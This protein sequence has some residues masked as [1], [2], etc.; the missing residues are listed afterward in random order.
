MRAAFNQIKIS[1]RTLEDVEKDG[2]EEDECGCNKFCTDYLARSGTKRWKK[3]VNGIIEHPITVEN[4]HWGR[5]LESYLLTKTS[6]TICYVWVCQ[7]AKGLLISSSSSENMK[8]LITGHL[9]F[10]FFLISI[11]FRF[12]STYKDHQKYIYF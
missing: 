10:L 8:I 6:R 2:K 12:F 4:L 1:L 7:Y 9:A 11:I 5:G 3:L